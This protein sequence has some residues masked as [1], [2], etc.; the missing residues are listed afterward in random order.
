MTR[1][2][3]TIGQLARLGLHDPTHAAET[4][5]RWAL[6]AEV[7]A[8]LVERL[9]ASADPDQ[10][11]SGLDRLFDTAP[12]QT[13]ALI[14]A[15]P[16]ADRLVALL[17]GS[18][19]LGH[20]LAAHPDQ[21][22]EL[23]EP[24]QRRSREHWRTS[25]LTAVGAD[26]DA[27]APVATEPAAADRLRLAYRA[28]LITVAVRDLMA[29]EPTEVMEDVAGE[30]ADLADAVVE[31]ALAAARAEVGEAWQQCRLAIV[32]LGKCGAQELN[33][34]SDVDVVY[35]AEPPIDSEVGTDTAMRA[36]TRLAAA[37]AR[38]CSG[39][40]AA[41]RIWEL[42]AALR[43]EGSAGPLVRTLASMQTYYDK[44]AK[45]WEFQAMLK[46][47]AMAGDLELGQ[48]FCAMVAERVWRA[49]E[50][51]GFVVDAR[52]MRR[53]VVEHIP[54]E[55]SDRE[56][57]LGVGGL[58]DVEFSVQ[59]LQLVHGRADERL[60]ERATLPALRSL[61]TFG[62]VGRSD[63]A[64]LAESYAFV[65]TLEH[66]I[67]MEDLRRT[68]LLPDDP[69]RLRALARGLGLGSGDDLVRQWRRHAR[70][71][72]Q[73][74][75]R[76]F[77]SPVL[78]AVSRIRTDELQL[79]TGAAEDRL[80]ALGF[81]DPKAALGH[82]AALTSGV[83]RQA[84]IQ[85]Q[86]LP[87]ML[88]W[89]ADAPSPDHGLLAFRQI[90][91]AL[92]RTPW[93]LRALRDEGTTAQRLAKLL[94]SSRY[95][96]NLLQ[97]TPEAVQL[98]AREEAPGVRTY[99]QWRGEMSSAAR[100]QEDPVRAIQAI[101]AVRQRGLLRVA[102]ADV[103]AAISVDDVGR[104]LA[105][106]TSATI[107]TALEVVMRGWS[108]PPIAAI[109]MGR[110]GGQEMS[111][112]SD[113]DAMFVM[114]DGGE[115][116]ALAEATKLLTRLR[117]GL[118]SPGPVPGIEIDLG[119][120]PEGSGGPI[121]RTMNA[122]RT[123]Y[124]RWS[125]TW[126]MQALVRAGVGAGDAELGAE[127]MAEIDQHRWPD[128]GLNDDQRAEIRRLKARMEAERL[129]RG[130]DRRDHLKLGPGGLSDVEWTVQMIQLDHAAAHPPLRTTRTMVALDAARELELIGRE[131]HDTLA[132]AWRLASRI[133]DLSM[134]VRGRPSDTMPSDTRE[135][136]AVAEL[137]DYPVP[138][139]SL[140]Q[141]DQRRLA[142]QAVNVVDRLFWGQD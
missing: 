131:D 23:E 97:R 134:L 52:A 9:G 113:A 102:G 139:A 28:A 137:M 29:D 95:V 3:T 128:G 24:T 108:G 85:R 73:L 25:F 51:P 5:D 62:Y 67:Q 118:T 123:Y 79:T 140:L 45:T 72:E 47:R 87:V 82:V 77:Y 92:G 127:L 31:A 110:W 26:P 58:R 114:A 16:T 56:L 32:A 59:L 86:L 46:A 78:T 98:L 39:Y 71:V 61:V 107:D 18:R 10:V 100:R 132:S 17:A 55:H 120:R 117:S 129:P 103:L 124:A 89:L 48:D 60:R 6:P 13:T 63:G 42:D 4:L 115:D 38:I 21:L 14:S 136:A 37:V 141:S 20:H 69:D 49:G 76:V 119:L 104:S 138:G 66:R 96:V 30:L 35:V 94:A 116:G 101:R 80:Q 11:V 109:A 99:E 15:A 54:S 81:A 126:E 105:A 130:V 64:D 36:A 65:R 50:R 70:R 1:Q 93:Y 2:H 106:L 121:I 88:G 83:S 53:R 90:S 27:K 84:E 112:A 122:Y 40:S 133:R 41:G 19:S 91:E 43:P 68:H 135:L 111:Y 57:K 142:R 75:Q 125:S 44:W 33:Y 22:V 8:D 74:H 7:S 12:Q 34:V